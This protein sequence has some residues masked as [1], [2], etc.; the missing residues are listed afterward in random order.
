MKAFLVLVVI[1]AVVC[2][3]WAAVSRSGPST[4]KSITLLNKLGLNKNYK[5]HWFIDSLI[6]LNVIDFP[7][8]CYV[9]SEKKG[10]PVGDHTPIGV[11]MRVLCG[12]DFSYQIHT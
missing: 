10:F 8:Q 1:F 3:N 5:A 4:N 9:D 2:T 6:Q 11:C 12:E 7:N